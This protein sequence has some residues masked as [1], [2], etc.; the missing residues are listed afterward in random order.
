MTIPSM[1][2]DQNVV[3]AML[4]KSIF[5]VLTLKLMGHTTYVLLLGI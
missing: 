5:K 2:R 3:R 1:S 4:G